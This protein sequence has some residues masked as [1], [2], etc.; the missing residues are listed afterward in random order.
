ML[1]LGLKNTSGF[2]KLARGANKMKLLKLWL[3]S[4]VLVACTAKPIV[5][6]NTIILGVWHPGLLY[7]L[8]ALPTDV[9]VIST[10]G[11]GKISSKPPP[12]LGEFP[13]WSPDGQWVAYVEQG[14]PYSSIVYIMRQDGSQRT[15]VT[16]HNGNS[17]QVTWSPDGTHIAYYA[18]DDSTSS[19]I[20]LLNVECILN[21]ETECE[22]SPTFLTYGYSPKWAPD[23]KRMVYEYHDEIASARYNTILV[24]SM[25]GVGETMELIPGNLGCAFPSWSPDG[26]RIVV[27]C[28]G[29]IYTVRPDGTEL[30]KLTHQNSG[31]NMMPTWSPDGSKIAFISSSR[32][33][34]G[35]CL[36][37][38]S[39][40]IYS[41]ALYSMD[42]D[43]GNVTRLS[44]NNDESVWWYAWVP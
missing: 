1:Q 16:Y 34:L 33:G 27:N 24:I 26:T 9:Y 40:C 42:A 2:L 38:S 15:R 7:P 30:V 32:D 5:D 6:S 23:G 28:K 4:F 12:G 13:E 17:T 37:G 43:G 11:A 35:E 21:E 14:D 44:H 10:D 18:Y 22:L 29:D 8:V 3:I 19:G 36:G 31:S 25:D 41:S 39:D 20:Y